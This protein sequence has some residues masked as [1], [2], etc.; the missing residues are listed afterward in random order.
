M[1]CD[2]FSVSPRDAVLV[3]NFMSG[4]GKVTV[5]CGEV[6][7]AA[8]SNR[9]TDDTLISKRNAVAVHLGAI[10]GAQIICINHGCTDTGT[11][12][13]CQTGA[14]VEIIESV[15]HQSPVMNAA[16]N[17]ASIR[18]RNLVRLRMT[19]GQFTASTEAITEST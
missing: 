9:S 8:E 15:A 5:I 16:A 18:S 2:A 11:D 13:R 3:L 7:I 17:W 19:I 4:L 12:I 6:P 10:D 1:L 14:R